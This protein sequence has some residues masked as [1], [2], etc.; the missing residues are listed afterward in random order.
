MIN[1]IV[2]SLTAALA[3]FTMGCANSKTFRRP[4]THSEKPPAHRVGIKSNVGV[5]RID[6]LYNPTNQQTGWLQCV[7]A[8]P[9]D[10]TYH[11]TKWQRG[12]PTTGAWSGLVPVGTTMG[13]LNA[14]NS[15]NSFYRDYLMRFWPQVAGDTATATVTARVYTGYQTIVTITYP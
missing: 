5:P 10:A 3:I 11:Q 9:N 14:N 6:Y 7:Y 15:T 12:D 1:R 13:P 8:T 4:P 2:P